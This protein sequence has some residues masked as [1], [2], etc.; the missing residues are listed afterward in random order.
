MT[1]DSNASVASSEAIQ[2][3]SS[4]CSMRNDAKGSY[5]RYESDSAEN[6]LGNT[7]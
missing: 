4:L 1:E 5:D 3:P 2:I 7:L 6:M